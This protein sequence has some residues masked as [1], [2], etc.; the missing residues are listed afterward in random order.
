MS[1]AISEL[2]PAVRHVLGDR[3]ATIH[4]Y[5]DTAILVG[6]QTTV[7]MGKVPDYALTP[8]GLSIDPTLDT[9][10]DP[11]DYALLLYHVALSFVSCER[12]GYSWRTRAASRSY[13]DIRDF[14]WY[15][16]TNINDLENGTM[17]ESWLS[18]ATW[19]QGIQGANLGLIL[20]PIN[21]IT[22]QGGV[23]IG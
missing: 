12:A 19:L 10:S 2:Y 13:G 17:F 18:M 15:L 23:T 7:R 9:T 14:V 16:Q 3:D 11:N 8:D 1:T 20:T 5:Q 21:G 22:M 4:K 6:V